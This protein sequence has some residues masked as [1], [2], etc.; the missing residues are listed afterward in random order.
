MFF[1]KRL[2]P[3]IC[4]FKKIKFKYAL[5]DYHATNPNRH[6]LVAS[7]LHYW[8]S[9]YYLKSKRNM[10]LLEEHATTMQ[11]CDFL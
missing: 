7:F 4:L 1:F 9:I 6:L 11:M 5:N 2:K 10:M 8:H 3:F